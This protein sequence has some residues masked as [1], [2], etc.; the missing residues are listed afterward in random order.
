M[1][2]S[3]KLSLFLS[4]VYPLLGCGVQTTTEDPQLKDVK[5]ETEVDASAPT[6]LEIADGSAEGTAIEI[7]PDSLP[8]GARVSLDRVDQPGD[9]ITS[10]GAGNAVVSASAPIGIAATSSSGE[11]IT[12][13]ASPMTIAIPYEQNVS[14]FLETLHLA[15]VEKTTDNL[16][17]FLKAT[18]GEL[19]LWRKSAITID[20]DKKVAKFQSLYPGT[21]QLMY[22]G[23]EAVEGFDDAEAKGVIEKLTPF[24]LT[25]DTATYGYNQAFFCL[26]VG[27]AP[28][29]EDAFYLGGGDLVVYSERQAI[30]GATVTFQTEFSLATV[31]EGTQP[32]IALAVQS[33][34]QGC[35]Y[36]KGSLI[37]SRPAFERS[38]VYY[39]TAAEMRASKASG[40][41]GSDTYPV[42]TV[43]LK[44]GLPD[45]TLS[46]AIP[47][48]A[49]NLCVR[50][51][52][53]SK[54]LT[55][56]K[57]SLDTALKFAGSADISIDIPHGDASSSL[58]VDIG[59]DCQ[60]E[61]PS[62]FNTSG[63]PYVISA[64]SSASDTYYMA[65]VDLNLV[66]PG[67]V[68]IPSVCLSI[69]DGSVLSGNKT[70]SV[71]DEAN[72]RLGQWSLTPG[73]GYK[74]VLPYN[75]VKTN[76]TTGMPIF[77]FI[78]KP[79]HDCF[80]DVA[81][82]IPVSPFSIDDKEMGASIELSISL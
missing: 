57:T 26:V 67:S 69:F 78:V 75:K 1:N 56:V 23:N 36:K 53:K 33:T 65:V 58:L 51:I 22:C 31:Q 21:Y 70:T 60:T 77:D 59:I 50:S 61:W 7:P 46:Q 81:S 28:S 9:F 11:A 44:T 8:T 43:K 10:D 52:S 30:A 14:L 62:S 74:L 47:A 18:G 45:I 42:K 32:F 27:A 38:F 63:E 34:D 49:K 71:D 5:A 54:G 19:Y 72:V 12:Q 73:T 6:T 68:S 2:F 37:T 41:L 4:F 40:A 39:F 20:G 76:P 79:N 13:F 3:V 48:A 55:L 35:D 17:V 24:K 25:I 64:R 82:V 80:K 16:C 15:E 66:A 29:G